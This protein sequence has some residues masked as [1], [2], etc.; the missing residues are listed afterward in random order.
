MSKRIAFTLAEIMIVLAVIGVLTAVLLP[1]AINSTPNENVMKFKKGHN[2]LMTTIRELVNS[3]EYYLDGDLGVKINGDIVD[4]SHDGDIT[5]FCE[6]FASV[7]NSTEVDCYTTRGVLNGYN[8]ENADYFDEDWDDNECKVTKEKFAHSEIYVGND[9]SFFQTSAIMTFGART[10][11]LIESFCKDIDGNNRNDDTTICNGIYS[12]SSLDKRI[13][14]VH[15]S[16]WC[17][18]FCL[19]IGE[20]IDPFGYCIRPDGKVKLSP[21]A[22]EWLQKSIQEKE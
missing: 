14:D 8:W 4:G 1:V 13:N 6:T 21:R 20:D 3:D 19:D 7:V 5:N 18:I 22:Q 11:T 10:R 15:A 17:K 16:K 12:E 2:A 9:I